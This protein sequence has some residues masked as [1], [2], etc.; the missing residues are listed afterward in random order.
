MNQCSPR[1]AWRDHAYVDNE[2]ECDDA[3]VLGQR[4]RRA[5]GRGA[6]R[7]E[8]RRGWKYRGRGAC[9][10]TGALARSEGGGWFGLA[11]SLKCPL[12]ALQ[13]PPALC[14]QHCIRIVFLASFA[15]VAVIGYTWS[16]MLFS[17]FAILVAQDILFFEMFCHG[18]E[19]FGWF[20]FRWR[21]SS[22]ALST[23]FRRP[24]TP[25]FGKIDTSQQRRDGAIAGI[26]IARESTCFRVI[27][28]FDANS[29][30]S[31]VRGL[32]SL[33]LKPECRNSCSMWMQHQLIQNCWISP[34]RTTW[35]SQVGE[36]SSS[37]K[38]VAV[39]WSQWSR[40]AR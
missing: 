23:K 11:L 12:S 27:S 19:L 15:S 18:E 35:A 26:E 30:S 9:H 38:S 14:Q 28:I 24:N 13:K 25:K 22:N 8:W 34:G 40:A 29:R 5:W 36:D 7:G 31:G 10:P 3:S 16:I 6:T 2:E 37:P 39:T 4:E 17:T 1:Q 33:S 32:S 21:D 20:Y